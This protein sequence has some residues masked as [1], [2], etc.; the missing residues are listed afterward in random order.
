MRPLRSSSGVA[1]GTISRSRLDSAAC[2]AVV[3]SSVVLASACDRTS[4]LMF[5]LASRAGGGAF[6]VDGLK[7][8]GDGAVLRRLALHRGDRA[9]DDL[10]AAGDDAHLVAQ[11][12]GLVHLVRREEDRLARLLLRLDDVLQRLGVDR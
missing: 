11:A 12:L 7:A 1:G 4:I 2:S 10:L 8:N 5:F 9:V 3:T 6:V